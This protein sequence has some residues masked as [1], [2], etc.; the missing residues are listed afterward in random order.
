MISVFCFFLYLV[1]DMFGVNIAGKFYKMKVNKKKYAVFFFSDNRFCH[2]LSMLS[3][4]LR[5]IINVETFS[6]RFTILELD[7][8]TLSWK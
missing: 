8:D 7:L 1:F 6:T 4:V 2:Y 3:V 5:Y